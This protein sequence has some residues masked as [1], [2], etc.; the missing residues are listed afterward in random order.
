MAASGAGSPMEDSGEVRRL[1][2]LAEKD[3]VPQRRS[4]LVEF[5]SR[6]GVEVGIQFVLLPVVEGNGQ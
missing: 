5:Q 6:T 3:C 2:N 4:S 1:L